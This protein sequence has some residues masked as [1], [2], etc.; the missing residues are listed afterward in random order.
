MQRTQREYKASL[1]E[2]GTDPE[3][4]RAVEKARG[5][6]DAIRSQLTANEAELMEAQRAKLALKYDTEEQIESHVKTAASD[7]AVYKEKIEAN[8]RG[9]QGDRISLLEEQATRDKQDLARL[10]AQVAQ[11]QYEVE[12][13]AIDLRK[14]KEKAEESNVNDLNRQ[15]EGL[16]HRIKTTTAMAGEMESDTQVHI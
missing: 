4:D 14:W 5:E 3:P 8:L 10:R 13:G 7:Y 12:A 16:N 9:E 2:V 1:T 11:A 15:I 6:V